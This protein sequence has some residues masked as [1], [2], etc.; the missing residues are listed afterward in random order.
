MTK[1]KSHGG[2]GVNWG[3]GYINPVQ[4]VKINIKIINHIQSSCFLFPP[5]KPHSAASV[6]QW[7]VNPYP[8]P[9]GPDYASLRAREERQLAKEKEFKEKTD[10]ILQRRK[11]V[12]IT[13]KPVLAVTSIKQPTCLKQSIK[14]FPNVNF[15]LIFT[16]V[17]SS[18]LP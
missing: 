7:K 12:E 9:P 15:V 2:W 6:L 11:W 3:I 1:C 4:K 18:H 16:T 17:I 8:E 5:R 14:M 13:V 10:V